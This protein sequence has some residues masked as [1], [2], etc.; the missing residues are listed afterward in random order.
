MSIFIYVGS[1]MLKIY[2][3][4][5]CLSIWKFGQGNP[6]LN[7]LDNTY[8]F[9][10]ILFWST[11]FGDP[12][13]S[14]FNIFYFFFLDFLVFTMRVWDRIP[15]ASLYFV[16]ILLFPLEVM[17]FNSHASHFFCFHFFLKLD[18]EVVGLNQ[19]PLI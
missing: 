4:M 16:L 3:R 8:I 19:T 12:R 11:L 14:P 15:K 18:L 6:V 1:I 17:G 2:S 13:S 5:T 7:S 10:F 9:P